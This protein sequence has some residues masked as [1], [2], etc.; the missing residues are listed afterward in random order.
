[1]N[2]VLLNPAIYPLSRDGDAGANKIMILT[3]DMILLE[4]EL[5]K[6]GKSE[7]EMGLRSRYFYFTKTYISYHVKANSP[8]RGRVY[9]DD[10]V[11]L[12]TRD[13]SIFR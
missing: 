9:F 4:G 3:N 8:A 11:G 2:D 5:R 1:M 13:E 12:V 7:M 6:A 10:V